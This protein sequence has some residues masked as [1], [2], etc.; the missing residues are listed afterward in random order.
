MCEKRKG[1]QG[2][3]SECGGRKEQ[4]VG[5]K[6]LAGLSTV[7]CVTRWWWCL[8]LLL[9]ADFWCAWLFGLPGLGLLA[10]I[11][12]LRR[13]SPHCCDLEGLCQTKYRRAYA[14][15]NLRHGFLD[16]CAGM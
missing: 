1:Q 2:R 12:V 8:L 6:S 4:N 11:R 13:V 15:T 9:A 14:R 16:R 7:L 10:A 3:V 5:E